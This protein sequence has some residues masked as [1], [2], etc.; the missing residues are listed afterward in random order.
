MAP[1]LL[2]T[3]KYPSWHS[4]QTYEQLRGRP[5]IANR[6]L[7]INF[8]HRETPRNDGTLMQTLCNI[9]VPGPG[10]AC[11]TY[12]IN[13]PTEDNWPFGRRKKNPRRL[14]DEDF[15]YVDIRYLAQDKVHWNFMQTVMNFQVSQNQG[16]SWLAEQPSVFQERPLLCRPRMYGQEGQLSES[17]T[18]LEKQFAK[19]LNGLLGCITR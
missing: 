5:G 7:Q 3:K 1:S 6:F 12:V 14:I 18:G 13:R 2:P 16:I 11:R 17:R 15:E 8:N 10:T 9:L 4:V 19:L